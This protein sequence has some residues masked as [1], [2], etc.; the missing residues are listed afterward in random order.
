[1]K[2]QAHKYQININKY[3]IKYIYRTTDDVFYD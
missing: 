2:Q 1:M 3:Y